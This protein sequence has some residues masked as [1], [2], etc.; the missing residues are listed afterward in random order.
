MRIVSLPGR[1]LGCSLIVALLPLISIFAQENSIALKTFLYEATEEIPKELVSAKEIANHYLLNATEEISDKNQILLVEKGKLSKAPP[2]ESSLQK[3]SI[4]T[5]EKPKPTFVNSNS[6]VRKNFKIQLGYFK[7]KR[8]VSKMVKKIKNNY[9]LAVDVRTESKNGSD[10]YRVLIVDIA[11]KNSA[12]AIIGQL[13]SD[14]MKAI[15]K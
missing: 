9:D 10:Y 11:N 15:L 7:E 8:N 6:K 12:Q 13:K 14:G 5:P 2:E 4:D 1:D 3:A